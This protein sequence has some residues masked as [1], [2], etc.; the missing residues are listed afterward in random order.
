MGGAFELLGASANIPYTVEWATSA[1]AGS[2]TALTTGV[3]LA[4]QGGTFTTPDCGGSDNAQV[5]VTVD[6]NDLGSAPA[7]AP[8]SIPRMPADRDSTRSSS[9]GS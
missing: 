7:S 1:G 8:N 3:T 6:S 9:A 5:I 2:G 4:G